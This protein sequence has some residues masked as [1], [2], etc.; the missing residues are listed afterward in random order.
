MLHVLDQVKPPSAVEP[1]NCYYQTYQ[2]KLFVRPSAI[3]FRKL[4]GANFKL[5]INILCE[6]NCELSTFF[7]CQALF[8]L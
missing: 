3:H 2:E 4:T 5:E 8:Q 1:F 7:I 6:E